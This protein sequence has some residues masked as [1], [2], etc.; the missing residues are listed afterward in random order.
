MNGASE[1]NGTNGANW[2]NGANGNETQA[3]ELEYRVAYQ[4]RDGGLVVGTLDDLATDWRAGAVDAEAAVSVDG[5]RRTAADVL[6]E[7]AERAAV[8]EVGQTRADAEKESRQAFGEGVGIGGLGCF[9]ILA[10][11]GD[12]T[13]MGVPLLIATPLFVAAA[14]C[15]YV[16]SFLVEEW[17]RR[18]AETKARILENGTKK[19]GEQSEPPDISTSALSSSP[20]RPT[21]TSNLLEA[22]NDSARR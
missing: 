8:A 3:G 7:Y 10:C 6:D 12:P 18:V 15:F 14:L 13:K 4:R 19:D 21:S 9:M 20:T 17:E 2:A 11:L 16:A 5:E 1:A 22:S